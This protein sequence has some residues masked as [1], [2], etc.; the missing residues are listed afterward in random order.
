M[1][2]H[3][4]LSFFC[5]VACHGLGWTTTTT[6][7]PVAS[8]LIYHDTRISS[9][10]PVITA[11]LNRRQTLQQKGRAFSLSSPTTEWNRSSQS[12]D[13]ND[14]DNNNNNNNNIDISSTNT[15]PKDSSRYRKSTR[16]RRGHGRYQYSLENHEEDQ[17]AH[18]Q[19]MVKT[20]ANIL[21]ED[22]PP[23]GEMPPYLVSITYPLMQAWVRRAGTVTSSKA[24]HVV[25]RLLQ[26]LLQER[27]AVTKAPT[28]P[29]KGHNSK[30][31]EKK[32]PTRSV[33]VH[34]GIYTA[35]LEAWS[36]SR[37]VGSAE[38][39]EEILTQMEQIHGL[40]PTSRSYN[41][42]IK[43]YVKNG[44]RNVAATK[45][46][47]LIDRMESTGNPVTMPTHR[48]YNLLLY[49]LANAPDGA[50]ENAAE[51]SQAVLDRMI[52]RYQE[53]G[54]N[55]LAI[56]NTNTFNQVLSA[57]A[58]GTSPDFE[59]RMM[60][61]YRLLLDW[62]EVEPDTD[63][64]NTVMGGWLKSKS[65][66]ALS[67]IQEVFCDMKESH[68]NGNE[69]ARPDRI[70]VN[71]LQV[72]LNRHR[73]Y[74][75]DAPGTL[76]EYEREYNLQPTCVSQNILMDSIIKSG[77]E[78]APEQV[79]DILSRMEKE[80]KEGNDAMKPDQC[81][82]SS[83]ILAYSTYN[84][85][86]TAEKTE[87]LLARAWDLHRNHG[88]NAPNVSLYN[89]VVNAFAS[90]DVSESLSYVKKIL[91]EM[92]S[93][94][95]SGIPRPDL[96]TYNTVIKSMRNG[97]DEDGAVFAENILNTLESIGER[98][99]N[100]LPDN[101]SYT[102]V[103]T[104]FARSNSPNKAEKAVE[105][106]KRMISAHENGNKSARV[107]LFTLNAALNA[108]AFVDG[109]VEDKE[110]AFGLA[111]ELDEMR[112]RLDLTPNEDNTWYGTMLR[113]CST[114]LPPSTRREDFV[115][116]F[117]KDACA[118][119]CV[120]RLVL[121]QMK[122]AATA[123]QYERLLDRAPED[124]IHVGDLPKEWTCNGRDTRPMYRTFS[125]DRE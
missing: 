113:A 55:C 7:P 86:N 4:L 79:M 15:N 108:C 60:D 100:F 99:P 8:A 39:A 116:R 94:E 73:R 70:S 69:S 112:R 23:P 51:R 35:V 16:R 87:E 90:L 41:A 63:S 96:V 18:L 118:G 1:R 33:E 125:N 77:V 74:A 123:R 81:S 34:T 82:Y 84:R 85:E 53:E 21:G 3:H 9:M 71:T 122:F 83:V 46:E 36:N 117:F 61:V 29:P 114:L 14:D 57:W 28:E 49:A 44:D 65:L 20:T 111:M 103:I 102:S 56:P 38:R 121:G 12:H 80:F 30:D 10:K 97:N 68:E 75:I 43:A 95:D 64:F 67:R 106:V 93:G 32:I 26:R 101:Y 22:A 5:I 31:S 91:Q 25:E 88:G 98:D 19:W 13:D 124:R 6:T 11:A 78:D 66:H 115:D 17:R 40:Q 2:E 54:A 109:S 105:I 27:N 110:R 92:E 59:E 62:P 48:S 107:S 72:A 45:V 52:K 76:L 58:K 24:P 47:E 50:V 104:A 89:S 119:G 120:G 37:E 42:V